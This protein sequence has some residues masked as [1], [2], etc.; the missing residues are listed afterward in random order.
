MS[1][2]EA[3]TRRQMRAVLQ[4]VADIAADLL[5]TAGIDEQ[6]ADQ[7]GGHLAQRL[8]SHFGGQQIYIPKDTLFALSKRDEEIYAAW[9]DGWKHHELAKRYNLS[10][11]WVYEVIKRV[12]EYRRKQR[13]RPI[14]GLETD[15]ADLP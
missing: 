1:A 14:P 13:Q 3:P 7:I 5:R 8:A 2:P 4:D 6:Q 15:D 11:Q 12:Q 10:V 9:S